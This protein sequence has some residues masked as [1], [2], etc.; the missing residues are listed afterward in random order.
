MQGGTRRLRKMPLPFG[1]QRW[2]GMRRHHLGN[3]QVIALL[4]ARLLDHSAFKP[5]SAT[6]DERRNNLPCGKG[7]NTQRRKLVAIAPAAAADGEN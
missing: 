2:I 6:C 7:G 1:K 4:V 3:E 5:R